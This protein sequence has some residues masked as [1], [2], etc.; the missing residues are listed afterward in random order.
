MYL[1]K[2]NAII[3]FLTPLK[4]IYIHTDLALSE[5]LFLL[6]T[7]TAC[8]FASFPHCKEF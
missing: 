5:Y 7:D 3:I 4:F 2:E 8:A 1:R 6:K